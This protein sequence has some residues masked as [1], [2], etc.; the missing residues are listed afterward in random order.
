MSILQAMDV[1][2]FAKEQGV[3]KV[4]IASANRLLE[5]GLP[6]KYR[7]E[8][9]LPGA[10]SLISFLVRGIETPRLSLEIQDGKILGA[11][12][13]SINFVLLGSGWPG[14]TYLDLI[15]YKIARFVMEH[16]HKAIPI[17]AGHPYDKSELRG[18]ISH[19]HAAVKAGLGE[20][21]LSTLLITPEFGCNV[22]LSSVL[23]NVDLEEDGDFKGDLCESMQRNCGLACIK[24]CPVNALKENGTIDKQKCVQFI[25]D[26]AGKPYGYPSYQHMVRCG[27]CLNACPIGKN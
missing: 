15:G 12:E 18:I 25:Y 13:H 16:G 22:Y 11:L 14:A 21:G 24:S 27:R 9:V 3:D 23:V 5:A 7:P 2:T 10:K 26:S 19:K 17:P 6:A 8:D 4:G 20:I 1:K